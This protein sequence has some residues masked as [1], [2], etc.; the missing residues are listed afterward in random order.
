[1]S[2]SE[3]FLGL[4]RLPSRRLLALFERA[5]S[6]AGLESF[7]SSGPFRKSRQDLKQLT[8]N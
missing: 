7:A 2:A 5:L 4:R 1:M 6:N 3:L 8:N